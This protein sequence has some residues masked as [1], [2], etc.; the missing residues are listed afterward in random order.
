MK[1]TVSTKPGEFLITPATGSLLTTTF[2]GELT[3]WEF[4]DSW[5]IVDINL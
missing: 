1:T 5:N 2:V 4:E 3:G